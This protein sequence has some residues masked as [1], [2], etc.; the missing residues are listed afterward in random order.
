MEPEKEAAAGLA[1]YRAATYPCKALTEA[2]GIWM[3][4]AKSVVVGSA[5]GEDT[6]AAEEE[7]E[8]GDGVA[9]AAVA[10]GGGGAEVDEDRRKPDIRLS[11]ALVPKVGRPCLLSS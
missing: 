5:M 8:D 10:A 7:D 4:L 9:G 1:C 6:E 11:R 3:N 2:V